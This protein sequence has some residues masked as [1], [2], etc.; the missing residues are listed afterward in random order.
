[1]TNDE[2]IIKLKSQIEEKKSK[3]SKCEKFTPVTNCSLDLE[4]IRFN[5]NVQSKEQLTLL[6]IKLNCYLMSVKD[7]K[8]EGVTI[9]G[10]AIEDWITDIKS[11]LSIISRKEEESKLKI[12]E[13]KLTELLS[14]D[15][16]I[17]LEIESIEQLLK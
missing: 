14:N 6:R 13:D 1:M 17:E 15:K 8:L 7:L 4:G 5:L 3:L 12:M 10:F 9:S 11:K 16:K 2:K